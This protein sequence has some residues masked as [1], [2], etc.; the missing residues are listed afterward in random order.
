MILTRE[1]LKELLRYDPLTGVF[2]WIKPSKYHSE[3]LLTEAGTIIKSR[4]KSYRTIGVL[5]KY[6]KAHRLAWLYEYG[7]WPKIID[8]LNGNSTDNRIANLR[9]C[10][11]F[12][13]C[14]NHKR[15]KNSSNLPVGVRISTSGRYQARITAN[16][17]LHHIGTFVTVQDAAIAYRKARETLHNTGG[18]K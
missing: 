9:S 16:G 8:H 2:I 5:G 18:S 3:K 1:K 17:T 12:E 14:Q 7:V 6:Y 13:N 4:G 11:Q 15:V 10:S